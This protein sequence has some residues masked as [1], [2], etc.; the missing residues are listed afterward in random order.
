MPHIAIILDTYSSLPGD[1]AERYQVHL[2]PLTIH[3]GEDSYEAVV[4]INDSNTFRVIDREG[5]L[6]LPERVRTQKRA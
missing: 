6:D 2:V 5:I 4:N 3:S 1:L